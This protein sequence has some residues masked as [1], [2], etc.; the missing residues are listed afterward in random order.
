MHGCPYCKNGYNEEGDLILHISLRHPDEGSSA[1]ASPSSGYEGPPRATY[2]V[3]SGYGTVALKDSDTV[4][5]LSLTAFPSVEF[6]REERVARRSRRNTGGP[7]VARSTSRS[8]S[9]RHLSRSGGFHQHSVKSG[10]AAHRQPNHVEELQV[11]PAGKRLSDDRRKYLMMAAGGCCCLLL[12]IIAI[13]AVVVVLLMPVQQTQIDTNASRVSIGRLCGDSF[14]YDASIVLTNPAGLHSTLDPTT[15]YVYRGDRASS[16]SLLFSTEVPVTFPLAPGSS[17]VEFSSTMVPGNI[18]LIAALSQELI[19][20]MDLPITIYVATTV[21]LRVAGIPIT[22]DIG[23][24]ILL[25]NR[26]VDSEQPTGV[27]SLTH[28]SIVENSDDQLALFFRGKFFSGATPMFSIII[29]E[30]TITIQIAPNN[31]DNKVQNPEPSRVTLHEMQFSAGW[32]NASGSLVVARSRSAWLGSLISDYMEGNAGA[33][34]LIRGPGDIEDSCFFQ[35]VLDRIVVT[36]ALEPNSETLSREVDNQESYAPQVRSFS[37]TDIQS[38]FIQVEMI[39][40]VQDEFVI[41][42]DFPAFGFELVREGG[43]RDSETLRAT[44]S[45]DRVPLLFLDVGASS[46]R[47]GEGNSVVFRFGSRDILGLYTFLR[48][49]FDTNTNTTEAGNTLLVGVP[50]DVSSVLDISL[51]SVRA[52]VWPR[53]EAVVVV[54]NSTEDPYKQLTLILRDALLDI[55]E[56]D[57]QGFT[58]DFHTKLI[59]ADVDYNVVL[60]ESTLDFYTPADSTEPSL[61]MHFRVGDPGPDVGLQFELQVH[62][63]ESLARDLL[64]PIVERRGTAALR[65]RPVA[66]NGTDSS[67]LQR[68]V[69]LFDLEWDFADE[70][71]L[72]NEDVSALLPPVPSDIPDDRVHLYYA[73]MFL[74]LLGSDSIDC[75]YHVRLPGGVA[76][77]AGKSTIPPLVLLFGRRDSPYGSLDD[78]VFSHYFMQ[79][80]V[81]FEVNGTSWVNLH[82]T[83]EEWDYESTGGMLES[84]WGGSNVTALVQGVG[85]GT[86]SSSNWLQAAFDISRLQYYRPILGSSRAAEV[87]NDDDPNAMFRFERLSTRHGEP[88]DLALEMVLDGWVSNSVLEGTIPGL[89]MI[90]EVNGTKVATLAIEPL[91]LPRTQPPEDGYAVEPRNVSLFMS[92]TL[93]S[94]RVFEEAFIDFVNKRPVTVLLRG[95]PTRSATVFDRVLAVTDL[96]L[97][98]FN[99]DAED[100]EEDS[101]VA[102]EQ[103]LDFGVGVVR[104]VSSTYDTLTLRSEARVT[105]GDSFPLLFVDVGEISI[106]VRID[107]ALVM[108]VQT[109]DWVLGR[110]ETKTLGVE[111]TVTAVECRECLE[112]VLRRVSDGHERVFIEFVGT[113][114]KPARRDSAAWPDPQAVEL[115]IEA[116]RITHD[117]EQQ[118]RERALAS[119]GASTFDEPMLKCVDTDGPEVSFPPCN[120]EIPLNIWL[121][122][123]FA[124]IPLQVV[125]VEVVVT[126]DDTDGGLFGIS[127]PQN[128]LELGRIH[129]LQAF[130]IQHE[131]IDDYKTTLVGT[132]MGLVGLCERVADNYLDDHLFVDLDPARAVIRI[133]NFVLELSMVARNIWVQ[134]DQQDPCQEIVARDHPLCIKKSGYFQC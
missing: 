104:M 80:R 65:G 118:A 108:Q 96:K 33:E 103:V 43:I 124:N 86:P 35:Q 64:E 70:N 42:G 69:A 102:D 30:S 8:G 87:A 94:A 114:D 112:S 12:I 4:D 7:M 73:T 56:W 115:M 90:A 105:F 1:I 47:A 130:S 22:R 21:V 40:E 49:V 66:G 27:A 81:Y 44:G 113:I 126:F 14:K 82:V 6:E 125:E 34:T 68:L 95:D 83:F 54:Q 46:I 17:T 119:A 25:N 31:T 76:T 75:K 101:V 57:D 16:E 99:P 122:N 20:N 88:H 128:G 133:D 41:E 37:L 51:S 127:S 2:G 92:L 98:V 28:A 52:Q 63:M 93:S 67:V 123:P 45:S 18:D 116:P 48:D 50:G 38:E 5:T 129:D 59:G 61:S 97:D 74:E 106:D 85:A 131:V 26:S 23:S 24:S 58:A 109:D 107:G 55:S 72:T 10:M 39:L 89:A 19:N 9:R 79:M 117:T 111:F 77:K 60:P 3:E 100:D 53:P 32:N 36:K 29:P 91:V 132:P 11:E 78:Y 84:L 121:T 134:K 110:G 120:I 62:S 15:L 71:W 13:F